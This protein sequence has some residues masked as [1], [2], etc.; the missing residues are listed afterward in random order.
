[1]YTRSSLS[2]CTRLTVDVYLINL[3]QSTAN[4]VSRQWISPSIWN[5]CVK[6]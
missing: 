4:V 6:Y 2:N 3:A 5:H 1:M